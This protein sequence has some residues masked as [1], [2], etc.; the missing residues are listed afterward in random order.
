MQK[1]LFEGVRNII[2]DLGGVLIDLDFTAPI[3]KF[4]K[5]G[6]NSAGFDYRHA[7]QDPVFRAF[8]T[9]MITSGEF[10]NRIREILENP[11]TTDQQIDDAWCSMMNTIPREKIALIVKLAAS[12][13]L[14][15]FSNTNTI[16]INF[17][18]NQFEKEYGYSLETLFEQSFYSHVIKDRKPEPSSFEKVLSL[19]NMRREETLFIDDFEEN[20]HAAAEFGL[21]AIH[22]L[23][24]TDLKSCFP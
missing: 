21:K 18:L 10:R 14:F 11:D 15:L 23:P 19:G 9:G 22:Y 4:E 16:H 20:V 5:L 6:M 3:R 1:K 12:Y 24:G 2:F 17:F 7:I 13:R 8:E